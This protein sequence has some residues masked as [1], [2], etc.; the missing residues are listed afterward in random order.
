[1]GWTRHRTWRRL[2]VGVDAATG[3]I[4]AQVLTEWPAPAHRQVG[5]VLRHGRVHQLSADGGYDYSAVCREALR[6]M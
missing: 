4:V 3:E 6:R 2:H 1:M 5:A